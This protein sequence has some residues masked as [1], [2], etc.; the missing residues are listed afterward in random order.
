[1]S[2]ENG[3]KVVVERLYTKLMDSANRFLHNAKNYSINVLKL[4]NPSYAEIA[5]QM[6]EVAAIITVLAE[7]VNDP[8]IGPKA[9]EYV[10]LMDGIARAIDD[11]NDDALQDFVAQLDRRPFL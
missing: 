9:Y 2:E 11:L 10:A 7:N 6:R 4:E 5:K 1:M 8:M 3:H